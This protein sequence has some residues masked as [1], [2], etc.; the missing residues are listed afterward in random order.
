MRTVRQKS[1]EIR[2]RL[3]LSGRVDVDWVARQLGIRIDE[4]LFLGQKVNEITIGDRIAVRRQLGPRTR[5]WAIAHGIG[6]AVLHAGQ[7]NHVFLNISG[8][9][10]DKLE[11]EADEFAQHLLMDIRQALHKALGDSNQM[12]AY[13]GVPIEKVAYSRLGAFD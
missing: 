13:Y 6:H 11:R 4:R 8:Q 10:T 3:G 1:S 2:A 12:A 7:G 5:R 9:S